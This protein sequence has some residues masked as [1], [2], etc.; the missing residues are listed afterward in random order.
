MLLDLNP[1]PAFPVVVDWRATDTR[2]TLETSIRG[3]SGSCQVNVDPRCW[4]HVDFAS[5]AGPFSEAY[6]L[7]DDVVAEGMTVHVKKSKLMVDFPRV[8]PKPLSRV[9]CVIM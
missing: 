2:Y 5:E 1:P 6:E 8:A 7:P 4:V 9:G 3:F